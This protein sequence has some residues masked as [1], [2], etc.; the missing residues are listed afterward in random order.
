MDFSILHLLLLVVTGFAA[1]IINT[2][3]GG[4]SN[5]T[6]PALMLMGMP[7]EVANASNR[8]GVLLQSLVG[9]WGYRKHGR[10]ETDDLGPIFIPLVIGGLIGAMLATYAP[11]SLLKP[12][13]LGTMLAMTIIML[14]RPSVIFVEPGTQAKKT[15]DTPS[16]WIALGFAGLYGGFVHAGV[17][18]VL[19]T[20][21]AGTLRYDLLRAN[22]LKLVC[23]LAFISVSLL[24]FVIRDQVLWVPALILSVG[25]IIGAH[26]AVIYSIRAKP[27]TLK[28]FLFAMT[29]VGCTAAMVF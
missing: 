22:A 18:F 15:R 26:I 7:P 16:S 28:W 25:F 14:V 12:M 11:S 8:V 13:L 10:L 21:L 1:G 19:I 27:Q 17:G 24:V 20:A 5:L 29:L 23:S 4:G 9:A 2:L 3:A 6:L